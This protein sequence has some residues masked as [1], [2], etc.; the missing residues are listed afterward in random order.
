MQ[1]YNFVSPNNPHDTYELT[2]FNSWYLRAYAL[3][4]RLRY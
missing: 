3:A 4:T 1:Y 2:D